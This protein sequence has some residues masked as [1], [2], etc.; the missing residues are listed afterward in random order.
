MLKIQHLSFRFFI[1]CL[2]ENCNICLESSHLQTLVK[3][4]G[5]YLGG[6]LVMWG[7]N[8]PP[9]VDILLCLTDLQKTWVGNIDKSSHPS[10][11]SPLVLTYLR[12][13]S[14]FSVWSHSWF[15]RLVASTSKSSECWGIHSVQ[16][17][18]NKFGHTSTTTY[19]WA[20]CGWPITI[21]SS[22]LDTCICSFGLCQPD[23]YTN[24]HLECQTW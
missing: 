10:P 3:N 24:M 12:L 20:T 15:D 2:P 23:L 4:E 17:N 16:S 6:Q 7:H 18:A 14:D 21:W 11:I 5:S 22:L 1:W 13:I 9:M 8:V 19:V